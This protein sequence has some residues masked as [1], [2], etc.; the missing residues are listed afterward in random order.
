MQ[1]QK[2]PIAESVRETKE[3]VLTIPGSDISKVVMKC[4][5][6][7]GRDTDKIAETGI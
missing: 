1:W 2:H 7:T 6:S 4:G 3:V 5:M